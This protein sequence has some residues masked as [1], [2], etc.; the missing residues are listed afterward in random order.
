MECQN[1]I[2][3]VLIGSG[4]VYWLLSKVAPPQ[5][6]DEFISFLDDKV[7]NRYFRREAAWLMFWVGISKCFHYQKPLRMLGVAVAATRATPCA[8]KRHLFYS[9]VITIRMN[10]TRLEIDVEIMKWMMFL[11][12][13][14]GAYV[15][16]RPEKPLPL[17]FDRW[18]S[19]VVF[20]N[21]K[22]LKPTASRIDR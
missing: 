17:A 14:S 13:G 3:S 12:D 5:R 9:R 16:R 19:Y 22:K 8:A 7:F 20:V 6:L 2:N 21:N 4:G 11:F 15:D 18:S 10:K 1:G